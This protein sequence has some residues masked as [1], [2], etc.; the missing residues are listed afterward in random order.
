MPLYQYEMKKK[1]YPSCFI[2]PI[3]ILNQ[4]ADP[5]SIDNFLA[6][7]GKKKDVYAI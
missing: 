6:A 5:Q 7:S 1:G 4:P 2:Q 3:H